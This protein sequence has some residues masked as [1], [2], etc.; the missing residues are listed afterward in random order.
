MKT[1]DSNGKIKIWN[2]WLKIL[3]ISEMNQNETL[4]IRNI[5]ENLFAKG[6]KNF[7]YSEIE[8]EE[9]DWINGTQ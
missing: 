1:K 5:C 7:Y 9:F 4:S 3:L 6:R 8:W 2:V